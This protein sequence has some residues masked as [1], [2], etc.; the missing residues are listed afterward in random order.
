MFK[1]STSRKMKRERKK[2][3]EQLEDVLLPEKRK[4]IL[5][6]AK[7]RLTNNKG[8]LEETRAVHLQLYINNFK[9]W[10]GRFSGK[11]PTRPTAIPRDTQDAK[12]YTRWAWA[13]M[14]IE[15]GL[16]SWIVRTN[17]GLPWIVGALISILTGFFA[18][19]IILFPIQGSVVTRNTVR[20]LKRFVF[21]PSLAVF[22][23]FFGIFLAS[24]IFTGNILIPLLP[25]FE[26]A[27]W[28]TTLSLLTLVGSLFAL[29]HLIDWSA[30]DQAEYSRLEEEE[31]EIA[32]VLAAINAELNE[33]EAPSNGSTVHPP[34][35][36]PV[37]VVTAAS[38]GDNHE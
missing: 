31:L 30:R 25:V 17:W 34:P 3:Q 18:Y 35:P 28:A 4:L 7:N 32:I 29:S 1:S 9:A 6:N 24:R 37:P 16:G 26:F 5:D 20:T 12:I 14:A 23:P 21:W 11:P 2:I 19:A 27:F 10:L 22:V 8:Q 38:G 15:A 13:G 33:G 36:V